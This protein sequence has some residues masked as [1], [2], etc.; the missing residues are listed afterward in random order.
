MSSVTTDDGGEFPADAVIVG[1]GAR[2]NTELAEQS[3]LSC[4]NGIVVDQSLRT[5]DPDVYAV[6]DVASSFS[7][8]YGTQIRVE[9][10]ANA[11]QGGPVAAKAMLGQQVTHDHLPYFFTDQY[12]LGMEFS[13]W[14]GTDGYDQLVTRGD[15]DGRAFHAFWL[16]DHR[17]IA[18]MHVNLWN[19]GVEPIQELIRSGRPVDP[20]RLADTSVPLIEL[21]KA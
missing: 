19:D 15:V 8:L 5:D 3:G 17:A 20:D 11:L 12:D 7:P 9:H 16:G 18:G 1:I 4:D 21:L 14:L 13:G 10:W 6:G 2:P